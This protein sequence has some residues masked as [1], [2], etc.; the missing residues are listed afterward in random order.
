MFANLC[1]LEGRYLSSENVSVQGKQVEFAPSYT[2]RTGLR[3]AWKGASLGLL[4]SAVGAQYSDANNTTVSSTAVTGRIPSYIVA[5]L[6]AGYTTGGLI[7]TASF[8]NLF[9]AQYFTRRAS[10]Y[11]GPGIIPAEPRTVQLMVSWTAD[12]IRN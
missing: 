11:P 8:N 7:V 10:S 3:T 1:V 12:V 9:N 5:D 2:V 6:T 4:V